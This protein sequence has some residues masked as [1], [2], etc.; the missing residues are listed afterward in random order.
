MR[1]IRMH[2][3]GGPE[4]LHL[5]EVCVPDPGPQQVR[6]RTKAVGINPFDWKLREG[7]M[8]GRIELNLPYTPG[9]DAV[10]TIDRIG[11]G[12]MG[13][14]VGDDVLAAL[15]RIPGGAYAE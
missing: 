7:R 8:R 9:F 10:G 1:A 15:N 5:D 14:K 2:D 11:A 12:V 13:W 4:V 6:V 3:Y